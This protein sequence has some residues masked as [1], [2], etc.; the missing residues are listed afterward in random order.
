V[1]EQIC[2]EVTVDHFV[3]EVSINHQVMT[4][5]NLF[6]LKGI[7]NTH[8]KFRLCVSNILLQKNVNFQIFLIILNKCFYN[9]SV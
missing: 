6:N 5:N 2:R 9:V 4:S 8:L 3:T 1:K 7:S